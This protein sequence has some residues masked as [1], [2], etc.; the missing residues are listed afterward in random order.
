VSKTPAS[1]G[2]YALIR[3][4]GS[5]GMGE[6][7]LAEDRDGDRLVAV[8][9][10]RDVVFDQ[11][12]LER[13]LREGRATAK[14]R[15]TNI[16]TVYEV[17]EHEGRPFMAMEFVDG[18][19]LSDLLAHRQPLTLAEKLS[20]LEQICAGLHFAHRSGIVHR[21]VK[22]ANLMIDSE[23]VVRILDFGI[24]RVGDTGMTR[25]G[26]MIGT[27][28]YMS[29]EQML[30]RPI[31]HRSD[32]FAVG[33]VAYELLCGE[34]AFPGDLDTG[35]LQRLPYEDPPSIGARSPDVPRELEEIVF[36]ALRKS[37]DDRFADLA[38]MNASLRGIHPASPMDSRERDVP[39]SG[40]AGSQTHTI[41]HYLAEAE[42][43]LRSGDI[44][45]AANTLHHVLALDP[46]DPSA[47]ALFARVRQ[48]A[49][50]AAAA[51]P[52]FSADFERAEPIA[53]NSSGQQWSTAPM[54]PD[55]SD[56]PAGWSRS[57]R[58]AIAA[59]VLAV[60][61]AAI[62]AATWLT[63][64]PVVDMVRDEVRAEDAPDPGKPGET[65]SREPI[66]AKQPAVSTVV[67]ED[68]A[69]DVGTATAV[70][71]PAVGT[72]AVRTSTA[73]APPATITAV[74][75][76][77]AGSTVATNPTAPTL[78]P[79][80]ATTLFYGAEASAGAGEAAPANTGLR[81]RILQRLENGQ[82]INVDTS[83][84][85]RSGDSVRFAFESNTNGYLYVV[86]EG[87][88][89]R[90][91]VL[92]PSPQINGGSNAIK[93]FEDYLVPSDNWFTF[94]GPPGTER[95]FVFLS[96]EPVADLPGFDRPVTQVQTLARNDIQGLEQRVRSRDLVLE[97]SSTRIRKTADG[98]LIQG[99]YVVNRDEFGKAV[100]ARFE[101]I[102][103]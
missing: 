37:P 14:L 19:A 70:E 82:E 49:V 88:S 12:L 97:T 87:S 86:S 72:P 78:I 50:A 90:W 21:D 95:V 38:E 33:A 39:W 9:V 18:T 17:G 83:T 24:A 41:R 81:Y 74:P 84:P 6:V 52:S 94:N 35:L 27:L 44:T 2:K 11:E 98:Q 102:H 67:D 93:A 63:P 80:A 5:G 65:A 36:R 34:R 26:S 29:P 23:G 75:S 68:T 85:F 96:K 16:V 58:A 54:P 22:P 100:V 77:S 66:D 4:L 73:S 31:D 3:R 89:G 20:Y 76:P 62:A 92:F 53:D 48:A 42:T 60:A 7:Y 56:S 40:A 45:G 28:C 103:R 30:G 55:G 57:V 10:L 79:A 64:E 47:L 59:S 32:I 51:A 61:A 8:K 91:M 43:Q 25:S 101:L 1:I 71:A 13:F 99:T 15:H 69:R 46:R